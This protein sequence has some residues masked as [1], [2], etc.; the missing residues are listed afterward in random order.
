MISTDNFNS[1]EVQLYVDTLPSSNSRFGSNG[2][3]MTQMPQMPDI[4]SFD[5]NR[6]KS[7]ITLNNSKK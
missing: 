5:R 3:T 2:N 1:G 4:S 7:P 6:N